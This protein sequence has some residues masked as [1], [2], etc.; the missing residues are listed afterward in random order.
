M[1]MSL[2]QAMALLGKAQLYATLG[3]MTEA[4]AA[5]TE[6][7][8]LLKSLPADSAMQLPV[9]D[10]LLR[11]MVCLWKGDTFAMQ[12]I[13]E[14]SVKPYIEERHTRQSGNMQDGTLISRCTYQVQYVSDCQMH[15][16]FHMH[17]LVLG[18]HRFKCYLYSRK[19]PRIAPGIVR[20]AT[21]HHCT[22]CH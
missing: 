8:T 3:S 1:F 9:H 17:G 10:W 15:V 2:L 6:A 22:G 5:L 21:A 13:G 20:E 19:V 11:K 18:L 16:V 4:E 14:L 12:Q 7:A